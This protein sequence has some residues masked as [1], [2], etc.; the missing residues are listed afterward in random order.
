MDTLTHIVLGATVGEVLIGKQL[1]KRALFLGAVAQ[2]LPDI[3]FLAA[4]WLSATDNL[5]AHRGFTHSIVFAVL[6]TPLLAVLARRWYRQQPVS[7]NK[8]MQFFGI[9]LSIHLFI[10]AC[11]AYGIGWFEPFGHQRISFNVIFVADPFYSISLGIAFVAL[12]V[13]K[14]NDP[15]RIRWALFGLIVSTTYFIHAFMNKFTIEREVNKILTEQSPGQKRYF[16]TPTVLN[17]WLWYV[18][19]ESDSG[20]AIGYRSV[21]EKNPGLNFTHF[22]RNDHLLNTVDDRKSV[23]QLLQFSQGFYTISQRGDT[24]LFNDLR[25]GQMAGWYD[26]HAPFVFHYYLQHPEA[27]KLVIQR[28]RLSG[29]NKETVQSLV[30]KIKGGKTENIPPD[31]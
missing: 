13:L 28:G 19:L 22:N 6:L 29:W 18:V 27:N 3:D 5:L 8:W 11:N 21:F 17:N 9:Q 1:G 24:L 25:F 10:D 15:R 14:A 31:H 23:N 7:I 2:S 30:E 20:Y 16:T 12:V 4:F 26:P